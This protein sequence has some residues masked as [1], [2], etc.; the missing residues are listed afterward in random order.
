MVVQGFVTHHTQL[1]MMAAEQGINQ[2]LHGWSEQEPNLQREDDLST[3][4]CFLHS[5]KGILL[6]CSLLF[7]F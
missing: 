7:T 5:F 2:K 4:A 6:N 3:T 1:H